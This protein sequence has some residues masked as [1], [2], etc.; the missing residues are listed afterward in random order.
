MWEG[1]SYKNLCSFHT[2]RLNLEGMLFRLVRPHQQ[3]SRVGKVLKFMGV[4]CGRGS[5][6]NSVF[7]AAFR[8]VQ[9]RHYFSARW[10]CLVQ[11]QQGFVGPLSDSHPIVRAWWFVILQKGPALLRGGHRENPLNTIC[12]WIRKGTRFQIMMPGVFRAP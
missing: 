10:L 2:L 3:S 11:C 12:V 1:A 7:L 8:C 5:G 4:W 6:S 9:W